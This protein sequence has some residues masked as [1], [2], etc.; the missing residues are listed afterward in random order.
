MQTVL[1]QHKK[2]TAALKQQLRKALNQGHTGNPGTPGILG[3]PETPQQGILGTPVA[4]MEQAAGTG[5]EVGEAGEAGTVGEEVGLK[6]LKLP[7]LV[8]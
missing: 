1:P 5:I 6:S 2:Q 4:G 7:P 3:N 8:K